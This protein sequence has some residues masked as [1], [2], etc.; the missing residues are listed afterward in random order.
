MP[1]ERTS[2]MELLQAAGYQTHGVGKM[3]FSPD[4]RKLWGLD[5][6]DYSEEGG[7]RDGDEFCDFLRESG[8]DHIVDP[9]GVRSEWY[10][11][12][13]PS[14][15]PERLH[16]TRWVADRSLDFLGRRDRER[17]FLLWSSFIKP[18]PPFESPVPWNRLYKPLEMPFP[19]MPPGY[20]E[21]LTYWNR[22]QNRY[23]WRDQ[24]FDWN[25]VRLIRAA[26]YAA[27]SYV[28]YN[29]GRILAQ[30]RE[31]GELDNTLVI[32]TSDH[33]E[34][35]GDFGSVGK[36]SVLDPA[37]RVPM[38][39]RYP[40]R[41]AAGERCARVASSVDV[42]PTCLGAAGLAAAEQHV[43]VDLGDLAKGNS[44]RD[45]VLCQFQEDA[46]GL[47][48]LITD[49][50][51]YMHSV[52]DQREWLF[53]RLAGQLESR[54]LAGSPPYEGV[55]VAMRERLIEWFRADG[56]EGPLEG[57]GWR[58]FPTRDVPSN[59]DAGHLFQDGK[60]VDELFPDGYAPRCDASR[61][62]PVR[63]L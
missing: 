47:Y 12:P 23:K 59:P 37:A 36:R 49:E 57:D 8:F 56:Y 63:G 52:P 17:P 40:E 53:P 42:A 11:V 58:E 41:F 2:L 50:F 55:L 33:G 14:Q 15:L 34:L 3:H 39:V 30:L 21:L 9:Y 44:D 7:M 20:E 62:V 32:Y 60:S 29:A 10:Y 18:H 51:K 22:T 6:R 25:L 16:N 43:G 38:L 1:Q 31:E 26:Y 24:G 28:D 35:L 61:G 45:A 46:V 19:H 4:S 27:I 48:G 5:S 13:Q 54:S